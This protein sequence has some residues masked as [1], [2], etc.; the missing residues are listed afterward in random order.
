MHVLH[1]EVRGYVLKGLT[2]V[3]LVGIFLFVLE[4][5]NNWLFVQGPDKVIEFTQSFGP[6]A[7]PLF[8]LIFTITNLFLLPAYALVFLA[9][10]GFGMKFALA[11][12]AIGLWISAT[13][14]FYIGK[15]IK[16]GVHPPWISPEKTKKIKE[17]IALHGFSLVLTLRYLGFSFNATSY[18]SGMA[19]LKYK[20][21]IYATMLGEAPYLFVYIYAS[22][23]LLDMHS[24]AFVYP[25][26]IFK[27][28]VVLS[29][30]AGMTFIRLPKRKH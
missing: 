25:Y 1:K 11:L 30:V 26:L 28:V 13:I 19:K 10:L 18:A 8:L 17:Y 15:H 3:L 5:Y 2:A 9:G 23:L 4:E 14:N 7:A 29:F 21:Y 12:C 22:S 16:R 24:S 27:F 20:P 6:W